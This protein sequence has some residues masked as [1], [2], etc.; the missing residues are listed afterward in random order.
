MLA[1]LIIEGLAIGLLGLLVVGLLRSHAE[2]LR[3]L[4]EMGEGLDDDQAPR[5][6]RRDNAGVTGG[7]DGRACLRPQ[8]SD[9]R[10]R[11]RRRSGS[12]GRRGPTLLAFLS[13]T[14]YTCEPFWQCAV[15]RRR[16][17]WRR[18]GDRRCAGRR[19]PRQAAPARR[20]GPAR[21][22]RRTPRG[23]T[24]TSPAHPTSSMSTVRQVGSS[25]KGTA[26]TWAP[27]AGFARAGH[28]RGCE[29]AERRPA[30][31]RPR[32]RRANRSR[33]ARR[34][35]RAGAPESVS[36][37]RRTSRQQPV[38]HLTAHLMNAHG[39]RIDAPPAWDV[40]VYRRA[41]GVEERT[42]PVMH[43]ANFA[44]PSRRGDFGSGAV[45]LMGPS[46]VLV[47]LFEHDPQA[48]RKGA[49]QPDAA[50]QR[51]APRTSRRAHCSERFAAR[52]ACSTSST[53]R[54][55][56]S[57]STSSSAAMPG[58]GGSSTAANRA[59]PVSDDPMTLTVTAAGCPRP[60][61]VPRN[62]G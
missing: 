61:A 3:R 48:G 5:S 13:A 30:I 46:D 45:E 62:D 40:R 16:R 34:G 57:V 8:R 1:I 60:P 15:D 50:G 49:V 58:G 56:P 36:R 47:V 14:C 25:A 44:L 6:P 19:Q 54:A 11:N 2:I 26:G 42:F 9:P 39:L 59:G 24:M 23:L 32:Q 17:P 10:R 53:R 38:D 41:P 20:P 12:S 27:G 22:E 31:R 51:L 37:H 52:A 33:T 7:I 55:A 35:H 4:H 18:P 21:R 43:A 29:V 28:R